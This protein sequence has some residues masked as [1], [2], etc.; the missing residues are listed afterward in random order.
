MFCHFIY[1]CYICSGNQRYSTMARPISDET[2]HKV[3][4]HIN[5]GYRYATLRPRVTNE[6]TGKRMNKSIH[7]GTVT[8]SLKFIPGKAYLYMPPAERK[9]LVFPQGWDLS[10]LDS[11]PSTRKAGRPS[12]NGDAQNRLYGDVWLMERVAEKRD[13][14]RLRPRA[15]CL[16]ETLPVLRSQSL[17]K[18][19]RPYCAFVQ[20]E[21]ERW[22]SV[23]LTPQAG[24]LTGAAWPTYAGGTT[25]RTLPWR[26]RMKL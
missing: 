10:E 7:L 12:Y 2:A 13:T 6:A 3:T 23:L 1:Y 9:Q 26:R 17:R 24:R 25:R 18:T 22:S 15:K 21:L 16:R 19:A 11:L 20:K 8:E 4:L 5:N 14:P